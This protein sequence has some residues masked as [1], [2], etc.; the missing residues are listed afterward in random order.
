MST[1]D[2]CP[3]N[4]TAISPLSRGYF[5]G[6]LQPP[7][8]AIPDRES[9]EYMLE[10]ASISSVLIAKAVEAVVR[11]ADLPLGYIFK[12]K[13]PGKVKTTDRLGVWVQ[14]ECH[15]ALS[16][17]ITDDPQISALA[18]RYQVLVRPGYGINQTSQKRIRMDT[19][20]FQQGVS[21]PVGWLRMATLAAAYKGHRL[22]SSQAQPFVTAT[23][24]EMQL[25]ARRDM[26]LQE[27]RGAIHQAAEALGSMLTPEEAEAAQR[28][29]LLS[30]HVLARTGHVLT[31]KSFG[32]LHD[33]S[34]DE[35]NR[36]ELVEREE[37][38]GPIKPKREQPIACPASYRFAFNPEGAVAR[39]ALYKLLSASINAMGQRDLFG[40]TLVIRRR[41]ISVATAELEEKLRAER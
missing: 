19:L 41:T 36:F 13:P 8:G 7:T 34:I 23:L 5:H 17:E 21:E 18:N 29:K 27:V 9:D 37:G 3:R 38:F 35:D 31:A 24:K 28:Y 20:Q 25:S 40:E 32:E 12:H 2:K 10:R 26:A 4:R 33:V 1:V 15:E 39:S 6:N 14:N 11:P 30:A 22:V 16:E